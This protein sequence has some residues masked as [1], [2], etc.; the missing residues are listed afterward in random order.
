MEISAVA[1]RHG[2]EVVEIIA[3]GRDVTERRRNELERSRLAD[4]LSLIL[5]SASEGIYGIDI[6]G[7]CTMMNRAAASMLGCERDS[8]IGA[9]LQSSIHT[10]LT[11]SRYPDAAGRTVA[12]RHGDPH[13]AA[14]RAPG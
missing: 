3:F 6:N 9:S 11:G 2:G 4:Q 10:P 14:A 5:E 1:L 7:R 13:L 8:L 12:L